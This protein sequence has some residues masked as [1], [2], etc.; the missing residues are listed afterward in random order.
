MIKKINSI[1]IGLGKIGL[2]DPKLKKYNKLL[3]HCESLDKINFFNLAYAIDKK[4]KQRQIF[5]KYFKSPA[6][7]KIS[8]VPRHIKIDLVIISVPSELHFKFVKDSVKKFK[9]KVILIEKPFCKNLRQAQIIEK[10][11]EKNN[12]KIF[13]NYQRRMIEELKISIKSTKKNFTKGNAIIYG[14]LI[15]NGS[16]FLDLC[17][18]LFGN[19]EE[20]YRFSKLNYSRNLGDYLGKYRVL[21]SNADINFENQINKKNFFEL[22]LK[23]RITNIKLSQTMQKYKNHKIPKIKLQI[24]DKKKKVKKYLSINIRNYQKK[25]Y[26][27]IINF[28]KKKKNDLT[29]VKEAIQVKKIINEIIG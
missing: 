13:V 27:Q 12:I 6:Y 15:N 23:N 18:Y 5:E 3:S 11:C 24:F 20:V 2:G 28:F 16:H 26:L 29:N 22:S 19:C 25:V 17:N 1:V 7:D 14:G 21:F 4:K 9:P 8:L 10:I